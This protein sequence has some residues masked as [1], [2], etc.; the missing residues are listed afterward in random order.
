MATPQ[1][2]WIDE[3]ARRCGFADGAVLADAYALRRYRLDQIYRAATKELAADLDEVTTLPKELRV[4]LGEKGFSFDSLVPTVVQR[5]SDG[6]T[7]KG[8]FRL[9]DGSDVEAVLMEHYGDRSTVCISS[10]A[11]CA[12]ACAFCATGQA[13]FTRNL[14]PTEIFDQ[15]RFFARELA[16]RGKKITNIVFMGM[17]EPFAAYDSVMDA[18]RLLHD[19]KGF[20]L[21][22]R[23]ITI[24]T[25][26]LVPQIDR[27]AGEGI[28]VNL[29]ISLHAPND[30]IRAKIMPVNRRYP[31]VELMAA[32]ERYIAKTHRKVFF[33]Y[34][35]LE[36][37]NDSAACAEQLARLMRGPLYHVNL[38]PYNATPGA[39]FQGTPDAAMRKFQSALEV[40]D[41]VSTIRV[42]MG[43]DIAAACGQLR[44][45]TQPRAQLVTR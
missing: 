39:D 24:S 43:R 29:A 19:P 26:G 35:M 18:V 31:L 36:G 1:K 37:V 42:P 16:E 22:H 11:G 15:A 38:I 3:K 30:E 6:Q 34:V 2:I 40:R 5:S 44:A 14:E 32:V 41:V 33:E 27:F 17:G 4:A 12:Y 7:T 25:V 23:H 8:L 21:G 20:G 28:Q 9:A 45:E 13:G 10:Q